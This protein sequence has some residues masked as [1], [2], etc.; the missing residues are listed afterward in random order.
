M[1]KI[2]D[3]AAD[4]LLG[5]LCS[6]VALEGWTICFPVWSYKETVLSGYNIFKIIYVNILRIIK[7]FSFVFVW[8]FFLIYFS[9][10]CSSD[11]FGDVTGLLQFLLL[12]NVSLSVYVLQVQ[13]LSFLIKKR[14]FLYYFFNI[15]PNLYF[16]G[17]TSRSIPL[18]HIVATVGFD[19]W[20]IVLGVLGSCI[21]LRV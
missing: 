12:G 4:F 9:R 10:V 5:K 13:C 21:E 1:E 19:F 7:G 14:V 8:V 16:L 17:C 2:P 15:Y 3:D 20:N 6:A 11:V 18:F